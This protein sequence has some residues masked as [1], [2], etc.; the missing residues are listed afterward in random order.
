M[1]DILTS[2]VLVLNKF[3]LPVTLTSVR[4]AMT[5]LFNGAA[6]A[7][8]VND[9][10]AYETYDFTS[11]AELTEYKEVFSNRHLDWVHTPS[12]ALIVPRVIRATGYEQIQQ[13]QLKPTRRNIYERDDHTCQYCAKK[14]PSKLLNLDHVYPQALGGKSTWTNLVCACIKCNSDKACRTPE[15]AGMKLIRQPKAPPPHMGLKLNRGQKTYKDW[16][17]FVSFVYW[18]TPLK[19]D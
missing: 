5:R 4:E 15:E 13:R 12:M 19:E 3:Y 11:W 1:E 16:D 8:M 17:A 9:N 7:V 2:E 14:K 18:N 6:Q 10:G